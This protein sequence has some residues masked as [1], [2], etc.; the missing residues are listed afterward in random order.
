MSMENSTMSRK[1][2]YDLVW[3]TPMTTLSKRFDTTDTKLRTICKKMNVP[4]PK[5]GYWQRIKYGKQVEIPDLPPENS[6]TIQSTFDLFPI[7]EKKVDR[8]QQI[9]EDIEN[10]CKQYLKVKRKLVNPDEIIVEVKKDLDRRTPSHFGKEQG[11][12]S[13]HSHLAKVFVTPKNL[14]KALR[15]LDAFIKLV[16]SRNHEIL[17]N[18]WSYEIIIG[19]DRYEFGIREK[20]VREESKERGYAFDYKA[21]GIL[22]LSTGRFWRKREYTDGKLPL[23]KQL[24][25]IVANLEYQEELWQKEMER[26]RAD[27]AIVDEQRRVIQEEINRKETERLN[28]KK[29]LKKAKRWHKANILREY[30]DRFEENCLRNNTLSEEQKEWIMWAR[31][32][33]DWF[34]PFIRKEDKFLTDDDLKDI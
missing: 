12:I 27:Q 16:R 23:E 14:M 33:A 20:Q 31:D 4:V 24:S 10:S 25:I 1:E 15:I 22:V 11:Y 29:L 5:S 21:T 30:I 3:S 34:D 6:I 28:F 8:F 17:L 7:K 13:N 18:G 26:H 2:L 19:D 32:K 9:K